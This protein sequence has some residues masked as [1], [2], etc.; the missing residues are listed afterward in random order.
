MCR[1]LRGFLC[2]S[3]C[4]TPIVKKVFLEVKDSEITTKKID[5]KVL[6]DEVKAISERF[7]QKSHLK[8]R[9]K[10]DCE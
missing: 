9:I 3:K 4:D 8:N 7:R 5:R 10:N 2:F 1:E 6:A